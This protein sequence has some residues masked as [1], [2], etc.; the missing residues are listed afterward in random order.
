MNSFLHFDWMDAAVAIAEAMC[1]T[2]IDGEFNESEY[3]LSL[4]INGALMFYVDDLAY[5][6]LATRNGSDS[7]GSMRSLER[8]A[9]QIE[10]KDGAQ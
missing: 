5:F 3:L 9:P 7:W 4:P 8:D 10:W 6:E 2:D 1:N